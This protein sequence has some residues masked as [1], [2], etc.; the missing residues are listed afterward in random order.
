VVRTWHLV[1][2]PLN[3]VIQLTDLIEAGVAKELVPGKKGMEVW[4]RI[5]LRVSNT[6]K[7]GV[8]G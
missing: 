5:F 3:V 8:A 4:K 2:E 1:E 6:G 7:S